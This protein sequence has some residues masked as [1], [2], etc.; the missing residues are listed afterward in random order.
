MGGTSVFVKGGLAQRLRPPITDKKGWGRFAG[1]ILQGKQQIKIMILSVYGPTPSQETFGMWR[2]QQEAG[3]KNPQQLFLADLA[4]LISMA[5]EKGWALILAGD[6]NMP[7]GGK[8]QHWASSLTLHNFWTLKYPHLPYYKSYR[9]SVLPQ[10]LCSAPDHL[11]FNAHS[12]ALLFNHSDLDVSPQRQRILRSDHLPFL[13]S[14]P[15][16]HSLS[17][18]K[19]DLSPP[20]HTSLIELA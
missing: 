8:L 18:S 19:E 9:R 16:S 7:W 13:L 20:H 15:I 1:V 4:E 12:M 5:N 2:T 11:F 10:K 17:L 6:F 3:G 14:S